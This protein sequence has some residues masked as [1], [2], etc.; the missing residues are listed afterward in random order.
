MRN[1]YAA[2]PFLAPLGSLVPRVL[3]ADFTHQLLDRDYLVQTLLPGASAS[4]HLG[5]YSASARRHL[6]RELGT[7][8]RTIHDVAG[9]VFGPITGPWHTS[10]SAAVIARF[11]QLEDAFIA[12]GLG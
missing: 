3:A 4:Q 1:E 8:T 11:E 6:Y 7:V 5:A 2:L 10:W 12:A 9:Q